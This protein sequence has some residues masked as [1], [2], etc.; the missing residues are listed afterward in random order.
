MLQLPHK[1]IITLPSHYFL[2]HWRNYIAILAGESI[3]TLN[4]FITTTIT[5]LSIYIL[6][7]PKDFERQALIYIRRFFHLRDRPSFVSSKSEED[8]CTET[9]KMTLKTKKKNKIK[10]AHINNEERLLLGR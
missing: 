3:K 10:V 7:T 4:V 8:E 2:S 6:E 5:P 9:Y 1:I